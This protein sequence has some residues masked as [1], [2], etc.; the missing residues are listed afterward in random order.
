MIKSRLDRRTP[1]GLKIS[2]ESQGDRGGKSGRQNRASGHIVCFLRRALLDLYRAGL[3]LCYLTKPT[4]RKNKKRLRSRDRDGAVSRGESG[5][6]LP[7]GR[8]SEGNGAHEK[9]GEAIAGLVA[10]PFDD[11]PSPRNLVD[12]SLAVVPASLRVPQRRM[13]VEP[14]AKRG[15]KNKGHCTTTLPFDPT[16]SSALPRALRQAGLAR[17]FASCSNVRLP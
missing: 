2:H 7:Y 16:L 8:G 9:T 12:G 1:S 3:R 11:T 5:F 17:L 15:R 14:E 10:E 4:W 13:P 6:P